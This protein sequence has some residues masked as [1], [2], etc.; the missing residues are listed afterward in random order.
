VIGAD[1]PELA[2]EAVAA[3][4]AARFGDGAFEASMLVLVIEVVRH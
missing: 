3:E 1:A 4:I 2:T